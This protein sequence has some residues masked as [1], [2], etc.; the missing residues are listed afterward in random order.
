MKPCVPVLLLCLACSLQAQ[1][2]FKAITTDNEPAGTGTTLATNSTL[3]IA[4]NDS[5]FVCVGTGTSTITVSGVTDGGSNAL[6]FIKRSTAASVGAVELWGKTGAVA[7]AAATFTATYSATADF[8]WIRGV[9]YSGISTSGATDKT[10]CEDT[11]CNTVTTSAAITP[12]N[13]TTATANELLLAC[14][15][16]GSTADF[17]A[18]SSFNLRGSAVTA[19]TQ[20]ADRIVS[21]TG[22]YPSGNIATLSTSVGHITAFGTFTQAGGGAAAPPTRTLLGVGK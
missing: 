18:A 22:T 5:P 20:I 7:N 15:Y 1:I 17:T 13:V 14:T 9:N 21:A 2:T 10:S 4:T 16:M 6:S 8:R 3:N 19:D 11:G 12:Q